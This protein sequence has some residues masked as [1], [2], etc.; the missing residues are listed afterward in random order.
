MKMDGSL[1]VKTDQRYRTLYNDLKNLAFSEMHEIFFVC[2]G[3]GYQAKQRKKLG[4]NGQDR[5]WSGTITPDEWA[6]YYA[7]MIETHDMDFTAIQDD[8]KVIS[9]MEEYANAGMDILLEE[10]LSQYVI[11]EADEPKI[12]TSSSK[13]LPKLLLGF[14]HSQIPDMSLR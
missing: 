5:F 13:E 10:I 4:K 12:D 3:F 2:V 1:R 9:C 6:C 14:I 8:Q 7:V 11:Y